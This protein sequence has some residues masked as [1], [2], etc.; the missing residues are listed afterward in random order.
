[1]TENYQLYAGFYQALAWTQ[2]RLDAPLQT[3]I[4]DQVWNGTDYIDFRLPDF[5]EVVADMDDEG[6][7]HYFQLDEEAGTMTLHCTEDHTPKTMPKTA[8]HS[9]HWVKLLG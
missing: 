6:G 9:S 7:I 2:G 8:F 1:M 3:S 4:P 5:F